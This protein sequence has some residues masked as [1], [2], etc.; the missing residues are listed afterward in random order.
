M[1]TAASDSGFKTT[2]AAAIAMYV[3]IS[4]FLFVIFIPIVFIA[5]RFWYLRHKD[6]YDLLNLLHNRNLA[7]FCTSVH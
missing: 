7:V 5:I 3:V 6:R 4:F 2:S 1:F